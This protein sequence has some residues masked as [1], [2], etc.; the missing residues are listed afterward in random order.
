[1]HKTTD[2]RSA[3]AFLKAMYERAL[4][5]ALPADAMRDLHWPAVPG[6][7]YILSVGK[8][9]THMVAAIE[10]RMPEKAD[11]LIVTRKGYVHAGFVPSGLQLVEASHPVPDANG[12]D[13]AQLALAAAGALDEKD[14]LLVLMSG[15]ASAL[16]PAPAEGLSLTQKQ[17]ITRSLLMSG[18]PIRD[19]NVVRKHLSAIK[20]GRLAAA[21][22]PA[23]THMIAISDIPGD[24]IALIGSGPTV[25]DDSTCAEALDIVD[26]YGISLPSEVTSDLEQGKLETPKRTDPRMQRSTAEICARPADMLSLIHISEPT[27]PY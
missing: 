10:K 1:M 17:E 22:W 19:M 23:A 5:P 18:A 7:T 12:A 15:G 9:A 11:G 24:D 21:A 26:R 25:A 16:L 4:A 6:R 27:R 20:G 14:L 8:A 3:K 2:P 13:A